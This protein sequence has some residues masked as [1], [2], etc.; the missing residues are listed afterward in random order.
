MHQRRLVRLGDWRHG[1][2]AGNVDRRPEV[3]DAFIELTQGRLVGQLDRPYEL[4][5]PVVT[6][7][8]ALGFALIAPGHVAY[9]ARRNEGADDGRAESA[10]SAGHHHLP[11]PVVHLGGPFCSRL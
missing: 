8:E 4:H 1:K 6:I 7:G 9:G 5:L 11:V 10:S 2:T 3:G